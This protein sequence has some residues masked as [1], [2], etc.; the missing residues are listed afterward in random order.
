MVIL[1]DTPRTKTI[2][3][4]KS[5]SHAVKAPI[6]RCR[7]ARDAL[8][9]SFCFLRPNQ[10]LPPVNERGQTLAPCLAAV[11]RNIRAARHTCAAP[12][13]RVILWEAISFTSASGTK[14]NADRAHTLTRAVERDATPGRRDAVCFMPLSSTHT[15]MLV[16][17]TTH[18]RK[19]GAPWRR[20]GLALAGA[21]LLGDAIALMLTGLFNFGVALPGAI[22]AA[23][24]ALSWYWEAVAQWRSASAQRR[25]F[26]RAGWTAFAVWLATVAVFFYFI[27][28]GIAESAP[29]AAATRA[30]IILGSGTP[31]CVA[32]PTLVARLDAG[33]ALARQWPA[34]WVVVSGG[35]DFLRECREADIMADYLT[36]H[37]LSR[38]R[39]IRED[40]STSTEENLR[41]SRRL[42]EQRGVS[43]GDPLVLVTSDFHL[44][45]AKRIAR[46]AGFQLVS[47][48]PAATP[49]YL[50]YNAWL[51]E[52]FAFISG[53]V[54][55]EF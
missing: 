53:W 22:G 18:D 2:H 1:P 29:K 43:A 47:D 30:I 52:Y 55:R 13:F 16:R 46:K 25:W 48:A 3:N 26:W 45:R 38:N 40:L 33:M 32:S 39:L 27:H 11:R 21:L 7:P 17:T 23:C 5:D 6:A 41:F 37:G 54:L 28:R 8:I 44:M 20:I 34:A 49:L 36:A 10:H 24:L 14:Q 51:R 50:R 4:R 12:R 19:A 9:T 15:T 31:H 42:L 35:R